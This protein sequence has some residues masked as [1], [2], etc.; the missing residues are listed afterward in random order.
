M[1]SKK[2]KDLLRSQVFAVGTLGA[3]F[4]GQRPVA[5]REYIIG[6][7]N[8]ENTFGSSGN[9][10]DSYFDELKPNRL[11]KMFTSGD[12]GHAYFKALGKAFAAE[13]ED[14]AL[15]VMANYVVV[16][17]RWDVKQA[18]R[19]GMKMWDDYEAGREELTSVE[20]YEWLSNSNSPVINNFD[21][22]LFVAGD[23]D[24]FGSLVSSGDKDEG[25]SCDRDIAPKVGA[26]GDL[27]YLEKKSELI[28]DVPRYLGEN[29]LSQS[30]DDWERVLD[31]N[32][33]L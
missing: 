11:E 26:Y 23:R 27:H 7:Y 12:D 18:K 25:H 31:Q 17:K 2:I 14:D 1:S 32:I 19:L 3:A 33:R 22:E 21:F 28:S 29:S 6:E 16:A 4:M 20:R 13:T 30:S 10:G 24:R 15:E 5:E 9:P 8:N